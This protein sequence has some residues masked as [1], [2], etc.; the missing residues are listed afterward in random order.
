MRSSQEELT[1]ARWH[2]ERQLMDMHGPDTFESKVTF[3][4]M[5]CSTY[6]RCRYAYYHT[7]LLNGSHLPFQSNTLSKPKIASNEIFS[8]AIIFPNV[9]DLF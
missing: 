6:T 3:C 9:L 8:G 7:Y 2:L 4:G 5:L 1:G